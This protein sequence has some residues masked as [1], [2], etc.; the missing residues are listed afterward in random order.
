MDRYLFCCG[1][2]AG[3]ARLPKVVR[4]ADYWMRRYRQRSEDERDR[5]RHRDH[6][7]DKRPRSR[8]DSRSHKETDRFRDRLGSK[9]PASKASD[10]VERKPVD[11]SL[12]AAPAED[13]AVTEA[14]KERTVLKAGP[15]GGAY[16]PPFRLAQVLCAVVAAV[17][18]LHCSK[19]YFRS[20]GPFI[21]LTCY[22]AVGHPCGHHNADLL[23]NNATRCV[24]R[25][26]ISRS[27]SIDS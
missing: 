26:F 14:P 25:M 5:S 24:A 4:Q 10:R 27:I 13:A 9:D 15:A 7:D 8:E 20:N 18:N 1:S 22:V 12:V 6:T 17:H 21:V 3:T 19:A 11:I 2:A 23:C 16:I